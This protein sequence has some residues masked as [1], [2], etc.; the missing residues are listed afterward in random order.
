MYLKALKNWKIIS[1]LFKAAHASLMSYSLATE[2]IR[3]E[4]GELYFSTDCCV[5]SHNV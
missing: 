3:A 1:F 4:E 2:N 5:V